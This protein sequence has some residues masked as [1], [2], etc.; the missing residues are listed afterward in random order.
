MKRGDIQLIKL[1]PIVL[2]TFIIHEVVLVKISADQF[3]Y[4]NK[5]SEFT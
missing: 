4:Q 1:V 5:Q 2:A 3:F